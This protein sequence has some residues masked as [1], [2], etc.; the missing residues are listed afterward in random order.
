MEV[1][2]PNSNVVYVPPETLQNEF[3]SDLPAIKIDSLKRRESEGGL[4]N[5][6]CT[7][8]RNAIRRFVAFLKKH[9][10]HVTAMVLGTLLLEFWV[11]LKAAFLMPASWKSHFN[12]YNMNPLEITEEQSK[13]RPIL[14]IH[15]NYHNQSAWL[16][17]AKK[18]KNSHLGPVYTV[19]LPNGDVTKKDFEIVNKKI[20]QIKNQYA[21]FNIKDI[22]IDLVGHSRGAYIASKVAMDH[23]VE[24]ESDIHSV[25]TLGTPQDAELMSIIKRMD[26]LN[27]LGGSSIPCPE[28]YDITG[29]YDVLCDESS[30][31]DLDH[32]Y[33]AETG[34]LGLL[35]CSQVHQQVIAW[36]DKKEPRLESVQPES[37]NSKD[38]WV[39]KELERLELLNIQHRKI[40]AE[41]LKNFEAS[42]TSSEDIV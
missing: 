20:E 26:N 38:E 6:I 22:T 35:Y 4:G 34:H 9:G 33:I 27:R 18:L 1:I 29:S 14:L 23:F 5:R 25:I 7:A 28:F 3:Q 39:K 16:D 24:Q 41:S 13:K 11:A 12:F 30:P 37:K 32:Q 15:G 8:Y 10:W 21:K 19:N 42:L 17:F 40:V 36:L 2:G 31:L